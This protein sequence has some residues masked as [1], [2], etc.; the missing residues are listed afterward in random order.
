MKLNHMAI[1]SLGSIG[2]R[3]LCILKAI[4]PDIEITLIRSGKG[5]NQPEEILADRIVYSVSDALKYNIQAAIVSSPVTE[6]L[7]QGKKLAATGIHLLMEKPLSITLE[8]ADEFQR[9]VNTSQI[10][11]LI[12]Y[13]LRYD[14]AAGM[15]LNR[16]KEGIT[17]DILQI[18]VECGSYLP[19]WRPGVD[20]L[21]S[22]SARQDLGGGVLLELSHEFDYIRW[23]FGEIESII[24]HLHNSGT[25]GVDVEECADM[26]LQTRTGFPVSLHL[27][28]NR[29]HPSRFCSVQGTAG[30]L[31]WNALEKKISWHPSNGK[32]QETRF[33]FD[34]D[35]IY[36]KQ[37]IHFLA[38]IENGTTPLVN[39]E[40]GI[41]VQKLIEAARQSHQSG[42][43]V[44]VS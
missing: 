40:D 43:R 23:F 20:Y 32:S 31:T 18:R 11:C 17:G 19:H 44:A 16:L 34:R 37:L 8:G 4:R 42:I 25:L 9:I 38:C 39:L 1:V 24:A 2:R 10:V 13:A 6:H 12:G 28:F 3:H 36:E 29:Q 35:H 15:F 5:R 7:W 41:E 26:I 33:E 27:D 14:P 22:V 21:T 30:E